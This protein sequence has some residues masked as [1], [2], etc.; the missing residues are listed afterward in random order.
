MKLRTLAAGAFA[1]ALLTATMPL[2]AKDYFLASGRWDNV[3]LVID[4]E[5]ALDRT[6]DATPGAVV[7]RLRV[8]PDIDGNGTGKLDTIASGQPI[9]ITIAPD[10][11]KA[12]VVNHSGRSKPEDAKAF[13]HGHPGTVTVLDMSKALDPRMNGTLGAVEAIIDT[14]GFGPTGFAITPDGRYGV[15]AHAEDQG[16]ED[17]GRHITP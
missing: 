3:V 2:F 5:K 7:N 13:Q 17:G 8:T 16:N 4:L 6:N 11:K 15:L 14:G 12:Y 10:Q 9:M 1:L